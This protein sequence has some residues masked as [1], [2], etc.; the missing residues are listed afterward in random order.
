MALV[1][2]TNLSKFLCR[3]L[4][5]NFDSDIFRSLDMYKLIVLV[6]ILLLVF[7]FP[8][9]EKLKVILISILP[10]LVLVCFLSPLS[11]CTVAALVLDSEMLKM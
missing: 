9:P 10:L 5:D 8:E 4:Y 6:I 11:T 1:V 7:F 3:T 2:S